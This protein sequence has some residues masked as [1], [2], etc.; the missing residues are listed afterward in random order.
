[1]NLAGWKLPDLDPDLFT[2]GKVKNMAE[3]PEKQALLAQVEAR[4]PEFFR[5]CMED[6]FY[7][8]YAIPTRSMKGKCKICRKLDPVIKHK[9]SG[10]QSRPPTMQQSR[11][12]GGARSGRLADVEAGQQLLMGKYMDQQRASRPQISSNNS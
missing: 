7:G 5:K 12:D 9:A 11:R 6:P 1:M 4:S 2:K 8:M 3:G 10:S